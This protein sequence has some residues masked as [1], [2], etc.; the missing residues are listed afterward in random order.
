MLRGAGDPGEIVTR[1]PAPSA[2]AGGPAWNRRMRLAH[3]KGSSVGSAWLRP[4]IFASTAPGITVE[5]ELFA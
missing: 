2:S 4:G 5:V 1:S 3:R